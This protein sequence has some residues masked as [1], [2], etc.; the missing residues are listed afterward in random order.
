MSEGVFPLEDIVTERLRLR[1]MALSDAEDV[2]AACSDPSTRRFLPMLPDPYT[3]DVAVHWITEQASKAHGE[4]RA[5]WAIADKDTGKLLGSIGLPMVM[6]PRGVAE[7]GYW[8]AP[9]ARGQGLATE[10][11]TAVTDW[12]FANGIH[13]MTLIADLANVGS[14]K[15]ALAS[16]F[17]RE[18]T[19]RGQNRTADGGFF[20]NAMF[21]RLSCD[22]PGRVPRLLPDLPDGRLTDGVVTVRPLE[23]AD[24]ED[25][26]AARSLPE[27]VR[28]SAR[29]VQPVFADT[30]KYVSTAYAQW[31]AGEAARMSIRDAATDAY[32]GEIDLYA[33][34]GQASV[35][36]L[37][38]HLNPGGRGKGFASRS[39]R[40]VA[41]WAFEQVGVRRL[42]AG[43]ATWNEASQAVV[44]RLGFT[45]EGVQRSYF[46]GPDGERTDNIMWSLLP[47]ELTGE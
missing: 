16:G 29:P 3:V 47:G 10:A 11:V 5:Q 32:A 28:S 40:L 14:Q 22:E 23:A 42:E 1:P 31:L 30:A 46:G 26:F 37:G 6:H 27:V 15:V 13:R 20:D 21:V 4:G 9:W 38:I 7:V 41:K 19:L 35:A 25:S 36:M 43:T 44:A 33:R 34:G 45:R 2:A 24:A 8:V 39:V 12:T 18:A 17:R